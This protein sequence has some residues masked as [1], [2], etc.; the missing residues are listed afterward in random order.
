MRHSDKNKIGLFVTDASFD[1][2]TQ[3]GSIGIIDLNT[4]KN[5]S[6]QVNT[7]NVKEAETAGII[8]SLKIASKLYKNVIVFCDNMYSVNET[9]KKILASNFWKTKFYYIQI[10]WLPREFT[11]V[12]DFFSKNLENP[13]E[14]M[15][16]KIK[17]F[18]NQ[19][20]RKN[21]LNIVLTREDK[22][23]ILLSKIELFKNKYNDINN[24]EFSNKVLE[25]LFNKSILIE[26]YQEEIDS[27]HID[28][29][30]ILINYGNKDFNKEF[31]A[32]I[33]MV[34]NI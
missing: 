18:E 10:V 3:V 21:V 16:L 13:E 32:I 1:H 5:Y 29:K 24:F 19:A 31:E 7:P 6:I 26:N 11:H 17:S 2:K 27:I 33:E 9:R 12:A 30:N 4:K 34:F 25:N 8:E 15:N 14:N 20:N 22:I 23:E 28:L